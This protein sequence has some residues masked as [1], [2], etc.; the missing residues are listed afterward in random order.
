[1]LPGKYSAW[2]SLGS[3]QSSLRI[4]ICQIIIILFYKNQSWV[5]VVAQW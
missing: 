5:G 1:M 3:Q 2:C 4:H